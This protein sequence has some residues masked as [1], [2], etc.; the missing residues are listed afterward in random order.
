MLV[1]QIRSG[2]L[3][4]KGTNDTKRNIR[5]A[6]AFFFLIVPFVL[7]VAIHSFLSPVP[8]NR[9]IWDTLS[10]RAILLATRVQNWIPAYAGMTGLL[11]ST[12][13]VTPA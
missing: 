4:T 12:Y 11:T 7:F 8:K 9:G 6:L 1:F 10:Q 3:A 5:I 2:V 13:I